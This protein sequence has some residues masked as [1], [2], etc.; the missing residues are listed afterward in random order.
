MTRLSGLLLTGALMLAAPIATAQDTTDLDTPEKRFSYALGQNLGTNIK[1]DIGGVGFDIETFMKAFQD[2][3]DGKEQMSQDDM[4]AA[5][6]ELQEIQQEAATAEG[7]AYLA[8]KAKE[9]GVEATESGL[10][11][12]VLEAGDGAMPTPADQ[13]TV[14]Y[15]G[16]LTDGSVFDSSVQRGQPATFGV[17]QVIPGWTEALQL[18]KVGSKWEVWIPSELGYGP[19]GAGND[20]PPNAVLNFEIELISIAG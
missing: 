3:F 1:N 14:H 10:L 2:A 8:E 18:M 9:A 16:R 15:T 6:G 7:R 11:Y 12:K 20:I 4:R 5:F 13:V 17:G 19:R